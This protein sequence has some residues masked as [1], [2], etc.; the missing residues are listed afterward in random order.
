MNFIDIWAIV[1]GA[2][3]II[4]LLIVMSDK[5]PEW[6]KYISPIG[7]IFGGF[8]IGRVSAVAFPLAAHSIQDTRFMGF[9]LILVLIFGV[10]LVAFRMLDKKHHSWYILFILFMII[11]VG[12]PSLLE[13]YSTV[14]PD[15]PKEDYL[16]LANVKEERSDLA[17]A[18][19]YLVQYQSLISDPQLKKQTK[20][21]I[22]NLQSKQLSIKK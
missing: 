21:K 20:T 7:F 16:L 22:I 6:K 10:I 4:S 17:G 13:K 8:A 14:F 3:S 2:A 15:V 5:F 11:T 12:I 9:F 19:K 1:A 18:I